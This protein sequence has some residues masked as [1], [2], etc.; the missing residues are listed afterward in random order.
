MAMRLPKQDE[1]E[2]LGRLPL[3]EACSKRDLGQI[4]SIKVESERPTGALLTREGQD[5]GIMFVI[6]EGTA[7]VVSADP[8]AAGGRSS[9]AWDRG[10]WSVS[11]P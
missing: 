10:T 2:L 8:D 11:C 5:G 4:A 1:V 7:E 3:F 9:G 6:V